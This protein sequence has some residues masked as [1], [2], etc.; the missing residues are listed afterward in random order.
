MEKGRDGMEWC[1]DRLP[2]RSFC[3]SDN[4]RFQ[5]PNFGDRSP[6]FHHSDSRRPHTR[7][8]AMVGADCTS[9]FSPLLCAS[10]QP[11]SPSPRLCCPSVALDLQEARSRGAAAPC[12]KRA[13]ATPGHASWAIT[14]TNKAEQTH[15]CECSRRQDWLKREGREP[16]QS[17]VSG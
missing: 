2:H 6:L 5:H 13:Q 4:R 9:C 14:D 12:S 16:A 7:A 10:L 8:I 15:P 11:S 1:W 3:N 17:S